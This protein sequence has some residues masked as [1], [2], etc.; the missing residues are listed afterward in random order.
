MTTTTTRSLGA[1][2]AAVALIAG[3]AGA[4]A[5][6]PAAQQQGAASI[7][8]PAATVCDDAN[9][10]TMSYTPGP[11]GASV[12]AIRDRGA[13]HVGVSADTLLMGSRNPLSGQI[14]GFDIDMLKAVSA[15]IFGD[16]RP[17][18]FRVITSAQRLEVLENHE[19]DLVARTFT[20]NCERWET[21]AFSAEY[22]T[23]GQKVLV[24]RDSEATSIED[25]EALGDQRVC[26]PEGTTTLE[27]LQETYPGVEAVS[28]P[29]HTGC[30]VLFQQGKVEAITGDDTI[31]A[32]FVAQD[33]YAK[34]VGEPFSAEPY[35]IGAAAD[36]VDLVQFVNGVLDQAKADG[37]WAASYNAWL[38]DLGPAPVPPVS[39]YGRVDSP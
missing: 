13:L 31:L 30:L 22:L 1:A 24:T 11:G 4:P 19:V 35:G 3:C 39:V 9:E 27:R 37:S 6:A 12:Q 7:A 33:P 5:A 8:L 10:S 14:E 28:A 20:M 23:A 16:A 26:A 38:G 32:G 36:Q 17:L 18:Q 15:A 21:I 34:V 29:T 25:L 2:L